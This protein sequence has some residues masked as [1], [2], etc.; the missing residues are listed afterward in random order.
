[1]LKLLMAFGLGAL[2]YRVIKK[3]LLFSNGPSA[4]EKKTAAGGRVFNK[5]DIVDADFEDLNE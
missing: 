3:W 5:A 2:G 1:M 4:F